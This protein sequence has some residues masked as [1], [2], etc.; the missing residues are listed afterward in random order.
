MKYL[1]I[2]FLSVSIVKELW[3]QVRKFEFWIKLKQLSKPEKKKKI[4]AWDQLPVGLIAQL[5]E[6]IIGIAEVIDSNPIQ[7]WIFFSCFNFTAVQVVYNCDDQSCLH[8]LSFSAV[9]IYG[10]LYKLFTCSRIYFLHSGF[11][12]WCCFQCNW[13][14]YVMWINN[15]Y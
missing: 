7:A 6:H 5:V 15:F 4:Q 10:P 1:Q 14:Y 12:E 2:R 9:Q 3:N 11:L 8:I 13:F